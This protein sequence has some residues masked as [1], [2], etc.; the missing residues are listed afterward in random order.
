MT[1]PRQTLDKMAFP[2]CLPRPALHPSHPRLRKPA[3]RAC[4]APLAPRLQA[5]AKA[6]KVPESEAATLSVGCENPSPWLGTASSR[7]HEQ[8][9]APSC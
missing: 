8:D 2:S 4:N 9:V 1:R 7:S 6:G 3:L 5:V